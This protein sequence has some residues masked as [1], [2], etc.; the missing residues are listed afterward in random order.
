MNYQ[1]PESRLVVAVSP[2]V[3][4][5]LLPFL[6][7]ERQILAA[8]RQMEMINPR[9]RLALLNTVDD[10]KAA[11]RMSRSSRRELAV[12]GNPAAEMTVESGESEEAK[13]TPP[14]PAGLP[15]GSLRTSEAGAALGISS[16]RVRQLLGT[17]EL[18]GTKPGTQW[19]IPRE[20]VARYFNL[21]ELGS[22]A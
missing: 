17:G 15:C 11:A 10:L 5:A 2:Q 9:L 21:K 1:R 12:V 3:A 7:D 4:E 16:R 6:A 20:S 8:T 22:A 19:I 13:G 14:D 18:A